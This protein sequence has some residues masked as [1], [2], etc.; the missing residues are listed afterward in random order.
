MDGEVGGQGDEKESGWIGSDSYE[1]GAVMTGSVSHSLDGDW[2]DLT[3]NEVRQQE[4]I[5]L[6]IKFAKTTAEDLGW[7]LNQ[8]SQKVEVTKC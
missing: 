6:Q 8:L 7:R 2:S 3:T 5:D 1:V 4:L